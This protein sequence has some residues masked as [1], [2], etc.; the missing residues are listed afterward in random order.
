[1]LHV[2]IDSIVMAVS[3]QVISGCQSNRWLRCLLAARWRL[4]IHLTACVYVKTSS[5][6]HPT[7]H[8]TSI[9]YLRTFHLRSGLTYLLTYCLLSSWR[10]DK[11]AWW[12]SG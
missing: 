12:C 11:V 4:Q 3:K 10:C 7:F 5:L 8:S 2:R 1:V 6:S 9:H